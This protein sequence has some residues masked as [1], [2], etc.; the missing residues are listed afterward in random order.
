MV[1]PLTAAE[2]ASLRS[3]LTSAAISVDKAK[4]D[5]EKSI[6][7]S[8]IDGEVALLNYKPGDI[9]LTADNKPM[10]AIINNET[11]FIEVNIEEADIN[12]L[13]IG[14]KSYATFDAL[15]GLRLEG[16]VTFISLTSE[17]DNQGIVTYLVRVVFNNAGENQ[18][19]EGMTAFVDFVTA[20][21]KDVLVAP[22][23]AVRNIEGKPS[24][25]STDG[26]WIPIS[27]GFTDGEYVEVIS[28]LN[29]GDKIFN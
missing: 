24:V 25:E 17:T 26:T 6:L 22:V 27:T 12:K 18:V 29:E 20:E 19:R 9:I 21:A 5:Y 10:A 14:Q 2:L 16:E 4:N 15:D 28:G 1:S 7:I 8:P 13:K 3:S 11:L 23:D